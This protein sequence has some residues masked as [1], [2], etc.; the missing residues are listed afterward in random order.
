M[1][2][3]P[4]VKRTWARGIHSDRLVKCVMLSLHNNTA[5]AEKLRSYALRKRLQTYT[6]AL[7]MLINESADA[8]R[9]GRVKFRAQAIEADVNA[10]KEA[11]NCL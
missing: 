5:A 7:V 4:K 9:I 6:E 1:P 2:R 8:D 10:L 11:I 3:K